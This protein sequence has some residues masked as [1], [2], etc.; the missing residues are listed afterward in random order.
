MVGREH[1][2]PTI[3]SAE[4]VNHSLIVS[5]QQIFHEDLPNAGHSLT[6]LLK[7]FQWV[8][9]IDEVQCLWYIQDYLRSDATLLS[10]VVL[11][12]HSPDLSHLLRA[13]GAL[14]LGYQSELHHL[15]GHVT[16]DMFLSPSKP[17]F[18]YL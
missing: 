8:L 5:I 15:T 14:K 11:H 3:H 6:L 10:C 16:L 17:R 1:C 4:L 12:H 13:S 2:S 9:V 18:P 7:I